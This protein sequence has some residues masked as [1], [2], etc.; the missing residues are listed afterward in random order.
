M[1]HLVAVLEE[2]IVV[3]A[4]RY[5]KSVDVSAVRDLYGSLVSEGANKGILVPTADQ[6]PDAYGFAQGKPIVPLNGSNL[7]HFLEKH[8]HK[9]WIDLREAELILDERS[10]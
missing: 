10:N 4:K 6:G 7:L 1:Y 5:A 3:Q 9:A 8:G 2:P